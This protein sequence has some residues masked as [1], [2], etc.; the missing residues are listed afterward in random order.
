MTAIIAKS[1]NNA[2]GINNG[3]PWKFKDDMLWFR[4]ITNNENIIIGKNTFQ[5]LLKELKDRNIYILTHSNLKNLYKNE[6]VIHN[7]NDA[8]KN[9]FLC[10]GK[11]I[12]EQFINNC[13]DAYVSIIPL[14]INNATH[15][16]DINF[17]KVFLHKDVII[18]KENKF[19]IIHYYN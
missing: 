11:S 4:F 18:K 5:P 1:I 10:G 8:P 3:L 9:S 14:I 15:Y 16:I 12:Y 2:I 17:D 7:I 19:K 6:H 13:K